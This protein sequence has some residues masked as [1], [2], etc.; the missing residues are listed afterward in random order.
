M[1]PFQDL[2]ATKGL[3]SVLIETL[4]YGGI[5]LFKDVYI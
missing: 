3:V 4:K 2:T 5:W 1:Y